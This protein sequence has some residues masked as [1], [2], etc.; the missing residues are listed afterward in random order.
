MNK[1]KFISRNT[2]WGRVGPK[3]V[4]YVVSKNLY[5]KLLWAVVGESKKI[6]TQEF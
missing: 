6:Q 5:F 3:K 4:N 2:I 1:V